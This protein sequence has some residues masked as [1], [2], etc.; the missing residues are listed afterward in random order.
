[1]QNLEIGDFVSNG[2]N[3]FMMTAVLKT[4]TVLY[5]DAQMDLYR[6]QE[7]RQEYQ[8]LQIYRN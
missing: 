1:M 2:V 4:G 7:D 3:M 5:G 8:A 6:Q